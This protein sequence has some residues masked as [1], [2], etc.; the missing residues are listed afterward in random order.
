MATLGRLL[1][2]IGADL[3]DLDKGINSA[4]SK[5]GKFGQDMQQLGG[6]LTRNVTLPLV[7]I[8]TAATVAFT[9][10]NSAMGNVQSLGVAQDRV[11]ELRDSVQEMAV[12]V[13]KSTGD[14]ADGLYQVISAFGDTSDTVNVLEINARAAAAGLATT[15]DAI[16]LTSAVT[17]G[18]GDTSAESVQQVADL[19]FV[20][21][22]L[23]QTT[24]PELAASIGRVVPIAANLNITQEEL[25]ATMATLTGVT[26]NAAEVSTQLRGGIQALM[27]PTESM[28]GLMNNL[29]FAN[30]AAMIEQLGFAGSMQAIVEAAAASGEPLQNYLASIEG[31]TLALALAGPQ[32][33]NYVTKLAAMQEAAG[34]ADAAFVAQTEGVNANGFAMQQ[35][36]I[37]GQVLLEKLGEGLAPALVDVM[38]AATPLINKVVEMAN[39][40]ADLD[41]ATQKNIVKAVA[42]VA[43]IGPVITIVGTLAT[44]ISGIIGLFTTLGPIISGAG[45]VIG[46]L[47]NPIGWI[48]AAVALLG[49]AWSTNFLGI[50]DKTEEI[51]G[52]VREWFT[53]INW[54]EL[55]LG[56]INGI[57]N[58]IVNGAQ[59]V[60]D[61]AR[62]AALGA[63]N[64]AK[65][66][67]GI[68]SPSTAF[69]QIGQFTMQG[70]AQGLRVAQPEPVAVMAETGRAMMGAGGDTFN[71]NFGQT[72][73][74][75]ANPGQV[76][77]AAAA[78]IDSVLQLRR[79][80][81]G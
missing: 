71:V 79:Q 9:Q 72:F 48:V 62:N 28:A 77:R 47:S 74:G 42:L 31:Q 70:L 69:M 32:A 52:K 16:N 58:G 39:K 51:L 8:G 56:I 78:G 41:P 21:V 4:S 12:D 11:L 35:A 68:H 57:K 59:A 19:A 67:L 18:Y 17:K 7:G 34:A 54:T 75:Q 46:L 1:I 36:A 73:Q 24:F 38:D 27:A 13:G 23:G 6:N 80:R 60:A 43:A 50:R 44:G 63:L 15:T 53:S 5:I 61:A 30:G 3:S 14:L 40:F 55:G 26:G 66:L 45:T 33:E 65:N 22:Q 29:G 2:K 10:L 25:F 49:L 76:Q 37:K 64:A 20:A 81:G